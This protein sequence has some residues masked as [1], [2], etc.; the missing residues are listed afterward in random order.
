[1][2]AKPV[3][4]TAICAINRASAGV[5]PRTTKLCVS[6]GRMAATASSPTM[7]MPL[8][9]SGTIARP[10][11]RPLD[12]P[13]KGASEIIGFPLCFLTPAGHTDNRQRGPYCSSSISAIC[14]HALRPRSRIDPTQ[15][16]SSL[17]MICSRKLGRAETCSS[18]S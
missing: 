13:G 5:A 8:P 12:S 18:H 7:K 9:Q 6:A 14:G 3:T 17:A 15:F 16:G 2:L 10:N 1:M 11:A 4:M